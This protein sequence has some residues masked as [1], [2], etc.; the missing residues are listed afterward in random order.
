MDVA[1]GWD[2]GDAPDWRVVCVQLPFATTADSSGTSLTPYAIDAFKYIL[3]RADEI[4]GSGAKLPVVINLSYGIVAGPH[5]GT[6]EIEAAI[7][8]M[9]QN[10]RVNGRD[11]LHVVI[12]SGNSHLGRLHARV[13]FGEGLP[14]VVSLCWRVLPDDLTPSFVEIHL[15]STSSSVS[16]LELRVT[17]PDGQVSDVLGEEELIFLQ[18]K[19]GAGAVQCQARYHVDSVTSR[20]MFLISVQ[21]TARPDADTNPT[22]AGLV[23]QAGIW[24]IE[25]T[26][27]GFSEKDVVEAWIQRDDTPFGY[28]RRGRQSYFDHGCYQR[29]DHAGREVEE[30]DP[31]CR[32]RRDGSVNAIATGAE[33]VVIGGV[34]RKELKASKYSA[35]GPVT[36]PIGSSQP[37]RHGPDALSVSDDSAVHAGIL[38]AGT[39]SGSVV[40]M[41]GTSVAAPRATRRIAERLSSSQTGD[42][43]AVKQVA[44]AEEAMLPPTAPPKQS[45]E[46]AGAGRMILRPQ[47]LLPRDQ[48]YDED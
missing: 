42:R 19:T 23:A 5:D 39:R 47:K 9:V 1:C 26:N 28:Q 32:V 34:I 3:A 48:R 7:D 45:P 41:N 38:A 20:G 22:L 33:S 6:H 4:G 12:P 13:A 29:Y 43:Q 2:P 27:L 36:S 8:L 37:N 46:R 35:G 18:L 31:D 15:P 10:Q 14:D 25:L 24:T 17:T 40:A 16:R 11:R 30:D 21:P 44:L